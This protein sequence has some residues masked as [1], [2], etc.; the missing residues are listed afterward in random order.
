[1]N[2]SEE[3][4]KARDTKL[5]QLLIE[6]EAI[7]NRMNPHDIMEM[8]LPVTKETIIGDVIVVPNHRCDIHDTQAQLA[9]QFMHAYNIDSLKCHHYSGMTITFRKVVD[10]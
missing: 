2:D 3:I 9:L 4:R 6:E 8:F 1:M 5:E 10:E 7:A